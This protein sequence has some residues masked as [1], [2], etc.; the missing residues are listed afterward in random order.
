MS[1]IKALTG[2]ALGAASAIEAV[3]SVCAL[4]AGVAPPTWN[5]RSPDPECPWDVIP[6]EP[7]PLALEVVLSNAYAFGGCNASV[8]LRRAA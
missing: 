2:H 4:R 7:R 3:A 1:S 8:V 6:N 5:F